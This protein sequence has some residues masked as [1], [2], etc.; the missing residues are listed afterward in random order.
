MRVP[1]VSSA[2]TAVLLLGKT[3]ENTPTPPPHPQSQIPALQLD[4]HPTNIQ[5]KTT[6]YPFQKSN[7]TVDLYAMLHVADAAYFDDIA[8]RMQQYDT[9]LYELITSTDNV[10]AHN[11]LTKAIRMPATAEALATRLRLDA[12]VR[13]YNTFA[14]NS[15][16]WR[17]ADLDAATVAAME[18][19]RRGETLSAF[20]AFQRRGRAGDDQRLLPS[21]FLPDAPLVATL[22]AAAW[23]LPSPELP[24]LLLD[25]SRWRSPTRAG[26]LPP[27][28]TPLLGYLLA[29]DYPG[30]AKLAFAQQLVAGLPDAGAWGGGALSDVEVRVKARNAAC[31]DVLRT[32]LEESVTPDAKVAILY[33][34][35]HVDDLRD[36]LAEAGYVASR[37]ENARQLTAWTMP[38]PR[39]VLPPAAA[40]VATVVAG[41][42]YLFFGA[43][44]W[45][46]AL[47]FFVDAARRVVAAD[48]GPQ[49]V[50]TAALTALLHRVLDLGTPSGGGPPGGTSSLQL[51]PDDVVVQL[52]FLVVWTVW[53]V[54]RHASL[55]V[56]AGAIGVRW[57]RGLFDDD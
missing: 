53:Y 34:A 36:R 35:Y 17:V 57:D 48:T 54:Q 37:V 14:V 28:L 4:I 52:S 29:L 49:P 8:A 38:L 12:Q 10:D 18:T 21:F 9:V 45:G 26:G 32:V 39:P 46:V 47:D 33:G 41:A 44:D 51:S 50:H 7:T 15:S 56:S 40:P 20:R 16:R 43:L 22:R 2:S 19:R 1:S 31:V 3:G 30:A 42:A 11:T 24:C 6:V 55:L 5:L 25:W 23:L 27:T 13:L